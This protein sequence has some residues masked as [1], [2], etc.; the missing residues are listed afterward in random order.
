M[1]TEKTE[2]EQIKFQQLLSLS[3][4]HDFCFLFCPILVYFPMFLQL[5]CIPLVPDS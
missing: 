2:R 4:V 5:A 1:H 3:S